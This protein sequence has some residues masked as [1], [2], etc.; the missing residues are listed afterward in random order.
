M[1]INSTD[2]NSGFMHLASSVLTDLEDGVKD[3]V[4]IIGK[5]W[6]T[7][8]DLLTSGQIGRDILKVLAIIDPIF[9]VVEF[10]Y[11]PATPIITWAESILK[12]LAN[13][14]AFNTP[15]ICPVCSTQ[16]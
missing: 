1:S 12:Q 10:V 2:I 3:L 8:E 4:V 7:I 5:E 14:K 15:C 6:P 9:S 13:L 16:P 11:P